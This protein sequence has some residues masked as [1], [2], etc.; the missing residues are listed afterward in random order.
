LNEDNIARFQFA[1]RPL[2]HIGI[3]AG[4][5]TWVTYVLND[6]LLVFASQ[7]SRWAAPLSAWLV[8]LSLVILEV[9]YPIR[10]TAA[11]D[12]DCTRVNVDAG[13][14]CHSGVVNLGSFD[15]VRL[16][17]VLNAAL[18]LASYLVTGMYQI[19]NRPRAMV[20]RTTTPY[21]VSA[22]ADV[23][24]APKGDAWSMDGSTAAMCG[25]LRTQHRSRRFV[26]DTKLWSIFYTDEIGPVLDITNE[27]CA[28]ALVPLLSVKARFL[29]RF[30]L[31]LGLLYLAGT[32]VGSTSYLQLSTVNL[33]N[34][35]WWATYNSTGTQTFL[36]NWFNRQLALHMTTR[37]TRLDLLEFADLTD[38]AMFNTLVSYM[39][40]SARL[41]QYESASDLV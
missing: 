9:F 27:R 17:L 26:F 29:R 4:E 24:L 23:F 30:K 8:W 35:R 1:P 39:P 10:A 2:A 12:R 19:R 34:D 32:V 28:P 31:A 3:L 25:F 21:L 14:I 15:R 40:T 38:Y 13:I 41:G 20:Q 5:A 11:I 22:G 7:Y 18:V 33:A 36:S 37:S 6:I 16:I